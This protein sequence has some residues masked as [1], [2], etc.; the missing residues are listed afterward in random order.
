MKQTIK[1]E[2][3]LKRTKEAMLK[4]KFIPTL[5]A[6]LNPDFNAKY[7]WYSKDD[8]LIIETDGR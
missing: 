6:L 4:Q 7:K 3:W 1:L 2:D 5:N 8:E